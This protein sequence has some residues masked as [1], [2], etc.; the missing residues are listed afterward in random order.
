MTNELLKQI[1]DKII[2]NNLP[3]GS[4]TLKLFY[5]ENRIVKYEISKSEITII[6][7]EDKSGI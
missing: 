7:E 5:H 4:L 6:R 1:L 3:F 2:K